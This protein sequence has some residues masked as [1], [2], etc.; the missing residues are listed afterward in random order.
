MPLAICKKCH[1]RRRMLIGQN[2]CDFCQRARML[3]YRE[4]NREKRNKYQRE[5]A[6][7]GPKVC[8]KW[9]KGAVLSM[10]DGKWYWTCGKLNGGPFKTIAGCRQDVF[11]ALA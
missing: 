7:K 9:P 5:W 4:K 2:V 3:A 1:T 10:N 8:K 6:A 11:R